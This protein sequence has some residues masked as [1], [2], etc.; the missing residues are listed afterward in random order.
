MNRLKSQKA[1]SMA[2]ST[3]KVLIPKIIHLTWKNNTIP[4]KWDGVIEA[5][6]K[7]HP[8]WKIHFTTD[9]DNLAYIKKNHPDFVQTYESFPHNIQRADAIRYFYLRDMGGVYADM[10]IMP[11]GSIQPHLE[12]VTADALLVYSG[13]VK[14]FTNS[15]MASPKGSPFWD[16]VIDALENPKLPWWAFSPGAKVMYTTGPMMLDRVAKNYIRPIALL[17]S[18]VFMAYSVNDHHVTK[19]DAILRPLQGGSWHSWDSKIAVFIFKWKPFII[20]L[21]VAVIIA[22]IVHGRI[23]TK[24]GLEYPPSDTNLSESGMGA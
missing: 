15:F 20:G 3:G 9:E 21:I 16:E 2:S 12:N 5:W 4:E 10:D 8:G 7:F 14:C 13:N 17:P 11:L 19:P 23:S 24:T 6:K 18:K 1:K 22:K